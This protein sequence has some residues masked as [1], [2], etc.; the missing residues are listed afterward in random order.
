MLAIPL[1]KGRNH[2][3][4]KRAILRR[5]SKVWGAL[6]DGELTCLLR[7]E[8]NA[9]DSRRSSSYDGNALIRKNDSFMGPF[10]SVNY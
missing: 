10:G 7:D 5:N 6:E 4:I 2:L 1:L 3:W 9:L 8:R